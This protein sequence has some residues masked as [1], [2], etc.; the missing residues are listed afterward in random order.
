[1]CVVSF[2][3]F[4]SW[5]PHMSSFKYSSYSAAQYE[6]YSNETCSGIVLS[7]VVEGTKNIACGQWG[8]HPIDDATSNGWPLQR[9]LWAVGGTTSWPCLDVCTRPKSAALQYFIEGGQTHGSYMVMGFGIWGWPSTFQHI[10]HV[11]DSLGDRRI[12]TD[13]VAWWH[14]SWTCLTA[15]SWW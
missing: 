10:E 2:K 8:R 1:M 15:F 7:R 11:L 3:F 14:S 13:M 6:I 5:C 9:S 12:D 4:W